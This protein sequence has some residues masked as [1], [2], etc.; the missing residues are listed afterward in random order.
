MIVCVC[1]CVCVCVKE[2]VYIELRPVV[3]GEEVREAMVEL[4]EDDEDCALDEAANPVCARD[5]PRSRGAP[6]LK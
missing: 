6:D 4:A 5:S 3:V 2:S 1:V